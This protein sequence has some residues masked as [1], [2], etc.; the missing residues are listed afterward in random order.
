MALTIII[1]LICTPVRGQMD[2]GESVMTGNIACFCGA[3]RKDVVN[4]PRS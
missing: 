4:F 3:P 2:G 1:N